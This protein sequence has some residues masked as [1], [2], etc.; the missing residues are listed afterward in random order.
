M[1]SIEANNDKRDGC[2]VDLKESVAIDEALSGNEKSI[3]RHLG[4]NPR[5]IAC[6]LLANCGAFL[7]GYDVLVQGAINA[8]PA[9]S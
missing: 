2:T 5:V 4:E 3:W 6:T 7:F 8:L 1:A 9:F